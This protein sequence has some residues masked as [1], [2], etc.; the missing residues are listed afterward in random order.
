MTVATSQATATI[1]ATAI[2][3]PTSVIAGPNVVMWCA[4]ML[5]ASAPAGR[6][7]SGRAPIRVR[8]VRAQTA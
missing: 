7:A 3:A 8:E 4:S 1:A 6:G 5:P 2:A